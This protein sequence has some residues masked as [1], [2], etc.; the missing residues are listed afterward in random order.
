MNESPSILPAWK[1]RLL[2]AGGVLLLAVG[3]MALYI[4][5]LSQGLDDLCGDVPLVE[6]VCPNGQLRAVTFRRD[7]GATTSYST[8]VSILPAGEGLPNEGGNVFIA[9]HEPAVT[10]RWVDDGHL[11]ISGETQTEFLRLAE[12]NG[13]RITYD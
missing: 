8:H 6:A 11:R 7:C 3:S 1:R 10:V 9:N 2:I 5:L 12:F 13:I 4:H